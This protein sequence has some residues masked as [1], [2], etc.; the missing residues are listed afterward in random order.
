MSTVLTAMSGGVDSAVCAYLLKEAGHDACGVTFLMHGEGD[1]SS[2]RAVADAIGIPFSVRDV[3]EDFARAVIRD[4]LDEYARGNTPNPCVTCNR[5]VKFPFLMRCADEMGIARA[6]TGHYARVKKIGSR[7][8]ISRAADEAKDQTYMLWSLPQETL[9][10]LSLPL[11]DY[12]KPQIREIAAHAGLPCAKSKESQDICFIPDGDY[13]AFLARAG[14]ALPDGVFTDTDG[15]PLGRARNQACYTIGQRRGLG[16]ALGQYMY[17]TAR[18][19]RENRTVLSPVDPTARI[20]RADRLNYLAAAEG[21]LDAPRRLT[22]KVR[23]TRQQFSCEA[24]VE[25]GVL[26]VR[27]DEALR[28]PASGQSIVLY[29]GDDVV[30]GGIITDWSA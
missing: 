28:A 15:V 29:D 26:T 13:A 5:A 21:D 9:A 6:A 27:F 3:R 23:Y 1:T 25:N 4:F 7:Y 18:D 24:V 10:R 22:A 14:M 2:A 20:V 16:I 12:T 8:T 19:A 11:G 30:L 17:V